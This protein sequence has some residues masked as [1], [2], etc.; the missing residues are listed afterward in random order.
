MSDDLEFHIQELDRKVEAMLYQE[1]NGSSSTNLNN[2]QM[3]DLD[4]LNNIVSRDGARQETEDGEPKNTVLKRGSTQATYDGVLGAAS[5][6]PL[7][8]SDYKYV[9]PFM[10]NLRKS[11]QRDKT[12]KKKKY[13][14]KDR[15]PDLVYR[16]NTKGLVGLFRACKKIQLVQRSRDFKEEYIMVRKRARSLANKPPGSMDDNQEPDE[17]VEEIMNLTQKSDKTPANAHPTIRAKSIETK[18]K[19]LLAHSIKF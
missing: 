10:Q 8:M 11:Q 2:P 13:P 3:Q 14:K 9:S 5:K 7:E 16:G 6:S 15:Y 18:R 12:M 4:R 17:N 19:Q 1:H